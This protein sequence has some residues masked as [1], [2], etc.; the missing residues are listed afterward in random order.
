M[1]SKGFPPKSIT[2]SNNTCSHLISRSL[3]RSFTKVIVALCATLCDVLYMVVIYRE[4]IAFQSTTARYYLE[5]PYINLIYSYFS[6]SFHEFVIGKLW[7]YPQQLAIM[8]SNVFVTPSIEIHRGRNNM[9]HIVQT[10]FQTYF[11]DWGS[12]YFYS[13][14]TEVRP[15]WCKQQ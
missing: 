9:A 10:T 1:P 8:H 6:I 12:L 11:L 2:I 5:I 14:F 3:D 15:Q 7:V 13:N 4:S